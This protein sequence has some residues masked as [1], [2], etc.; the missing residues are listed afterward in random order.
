[1]K[2]ANAMNIDRKSGGMGH[3]ELVCRDKVQM[4]S[5]HADTKAHRFRFMYVRAEA[6]TLQGAKL[7]AASRGK[8][9]FGPDR[10]LMER[11]S[12]CVDAPPARTYNHCWPCDCLGPCLFFAF[13]ARCAGQVTALQM[14]MRET[15]KR[16][17][18]FR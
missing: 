11:A 5:S 9:C 14:R 12:L 10:T 13:A 3:P 16:R 4:H 1:M 7:K 17:P 18:A 8:Q 2:L 15:R 6:R